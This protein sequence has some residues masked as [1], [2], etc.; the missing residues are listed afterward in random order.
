[1]VVIAVLG[2]LLLPALSQAKDRGKQ[3]SCL[4]NL[5]QIGLAMHLYAD[6]AKAYPPAY[7]DSSARWM[8]LLKPFL[9]KSSGV[10]LCP[11]DLQRIPVTWDTNIFLSYGMN[12]FRFAGPDACF[13]YPVRPERIRQ[14]SLTILMADCT[15]GKYYCGGGHSFTNPVVDVDY[16][17]PRRSFV[18]AYGDGHVAVK[19]ITFKEEWDAAK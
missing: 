2:A 7:V 5:R 15:P 17:H 1:M 19:R 11:S 12:V 8:D 16:R 10:Y 3:A 14:P 13:W 9:T 4:S 18:A 6:E